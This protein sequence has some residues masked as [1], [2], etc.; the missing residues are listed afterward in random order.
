[1]F[2]QSAIV[3]VLSKHEWVFRDPF[4]FVINIFLL[5]TK[6]RIFFYLK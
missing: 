6:V 2:Q 5:I 4:E 1:M 3:L